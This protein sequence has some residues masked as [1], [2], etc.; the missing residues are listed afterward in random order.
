MSRNTSE[1]MR[2]THS[3]LI[4]FVARILALRFRG[5]RVPRNDLKTGLQDMKTRNITVNK[6]A[7]NPDGTKIEIIEPQNHLEREVLC[8]LLTGFL[9]SVKEA[10]TLDI[11]LPDQ[12]TVTYQGRGNFVLFRGRRNANAENN[13]GEYAPSSAIAIIAIQPAGDSFNLAV[14]DIEDKAL[15]KTSYKN[16]AVGSKKGKK[17]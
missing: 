15:T 1:S 13:P 5:N 7:D 12:F 16:K 9:P 11:N 4:G 3:L 2:R 8:H 14:A 6:T 10:G 17:K